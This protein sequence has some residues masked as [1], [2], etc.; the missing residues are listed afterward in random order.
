MISSS[1]LTLL[2]PEIILSATAVI[3]MLAIAIKRDHLA[4]YVLTLIGTAA[5]FGSLFYLY[6][7]SQQ[8]TT[9]F[10]VDG[11]STFF[12]GLILAATFFIAVF[13]YP[14]FKN[15]EKVKAEEFY[16]LLILAS[17]GAIS[18]VISN[19]FVSFVISL[20]VMSVALYALIAYLK[21]SRF[22]IEA[23]IKYLIMA[24]VSSAILFFGFALIYAH[25]GEME[26]SKMA[27][28][29]G[30]N[31]SNLLF[32]AGMALAIVGLGFK[33]AL[34]P[35][36]L[37]TPDI[38]AGSPAPVSAYVATISK[39]AV[40]AFLLRFYFD[41]NGTVHNSVWIT[42]AVLAVASMLIGNWL[43]LQ[44]KNLKRL[45]AYSSIG[46]LG[47]MVVALL[48]VNQTGAEAAS[49]YLVAY[50][51]SMLAAFGIVSY[52]SQSDGELLNIDDYK[53]LFWEKPWIAA[54]FTGVLLSLAGIPLTAGFLG[55]FYLLLAG[56]GS[57][58]WFL[59]IILVISSSIGLYYYLRVVIA[60][61]SHREG[62]ERDLT[63]A[64][65]SMLS[66]IML[67]CLFVFLF[68]VGMFPSGLVDLIRDLVG[69]IY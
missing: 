50:F 42:F 28:S 51:I 67:V 52:L 2:C 33:L 26:L 55:K 21:D 61:F 38:Y 39:G 68:W 69:S 6:D 13:A 25:T 56:V 23:G 59:V 40:F 35:F 7:S 20:E 30:D 34:V 9:L 57:A 37:W 54:L 14:Y 48:A 32:L 36:H 44:Q 11:F 49:F 63:I 58:L 19:H 24:G 10:I 22:S 15:L 41:L 46:H 66:G 43:A 4:S 45:L 31:T 29:I 1:D 27:S 16:I 3:V 47:Y 12:T 5:A 18:M 53:G 17:V 62:E 64:S 60:M 65:P 8:V